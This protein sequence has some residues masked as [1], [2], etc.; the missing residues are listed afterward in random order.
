MSKRT[1]FERLLGKYMKTSFTF[2]IVLLITS[3]VFS[4]ACAQQ[5]KIENPELERNRAL[6][7]ESKILNYEFVLMRFQGG[8]YHWVP[9]SISVR[10]GQ[11]VSM[12]PLKDKRE[13]EKIDGYENFDTVEEIFNQI[14]ESFNKG[15]AVEVTYNKEFGY[16]EKT[17]IEP[18][19]GGIDTAF[20]IEI[21][22]FEITKTN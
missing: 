7:R 8:V 5:S 22:K 2:G 15:D 10:N 20:I 9:V 21:S 12:Q 11:A 13:L 19:N 17:R 4:S 6:W 18:R 1:L 14:Q 3:M 16:P